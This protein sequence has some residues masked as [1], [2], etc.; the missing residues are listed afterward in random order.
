M[1]WLERAVSRFAKSDADSGD[2]QPERVWVERNRRVSGLV[3]GR[4]RGDLIVLWYGVICLE[5]SAFQVD[6]TP[7]PV[8]MTAACLQITFE[9]VETITT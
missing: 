6:V 5:M 3:V 9:A 1:S 7:G 2:N 4:I 8:Q